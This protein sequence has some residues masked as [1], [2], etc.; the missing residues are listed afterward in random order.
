MIVYPN[1][2][3]WDEFYPS[4]IFIA[5]GDEELEASMPFLKKANIGTTI[6]LGEAINRTTIFKKVGEIG[7]LG[8]INKSLVLVG[9]VAQN[10]N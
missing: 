2:D 8:D 1:P 6:A 10:T 5:M 7:D 3:S 9:Y 4:E